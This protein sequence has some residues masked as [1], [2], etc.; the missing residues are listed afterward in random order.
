MENVLCFVIL[1]FYSTSL[2]VY[3]YRENGDVFECGDCFQIEHRMAHSFERVSDDKI[4]IE[5]SGDINNVVSCMLTCRVEKNSLV[6][7]V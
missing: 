3:N 1:V 7:A 2:S 4:A 5:T 6:F